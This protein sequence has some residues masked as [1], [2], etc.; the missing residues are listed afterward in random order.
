MEI[1]GMNY[2]IHEKWV[3]FRIVENEKYYWGAYSEKEKA[4]QVAEEINGTYFFKD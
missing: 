2:G 1:H 4:Q 3:V